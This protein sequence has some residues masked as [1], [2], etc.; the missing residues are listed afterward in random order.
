[1]HTATLSKTLNSPAL[2]A[3]DLVGYPPSASMMED[4]YVEK[5]GRKTSNMAFFCWLESG[6]V[7]MKG[8]CQKVIR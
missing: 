8:A 7:E 2:E 6:R 4:K 5:S 3:D 1:M